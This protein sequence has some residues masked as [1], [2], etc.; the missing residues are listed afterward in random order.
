MNIIKIIIFFVLLLDKYIQLKNKNSLSKS[1]FL[2]PPTPFLKIPHHPILPTNRLSQVFIINW[3]ATVKLISINTIHLKQQQNLDSFIFKF[4]LKYMLDN[5]YINKIHARQWMFLPSFQFL[6]CIQ[7]NPSRL[8]SKQL[9]KKDFL[10]G[11]T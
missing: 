4:T 3:N 1:W 7:R 11:A 6:C 2:F 9:G 5:V 8:I 10:N